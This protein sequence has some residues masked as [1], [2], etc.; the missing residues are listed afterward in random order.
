MESVFPCL[1][2]WLFHYLE[3]TFICYLFLYHLFVREQWLYRYTTVY[4][5]QKVNWPF[6]I[7]SYSCYI[8]FIHK[9]RFKHRYIFIF[10]ALLTPLKKSFQTYRLYF[11][12]VIA[13]FWFPNLIT[14]YIFLIFV[15]KMMKYFYCKLLNSSII[16][17]VYS[18]TLT[19]IMH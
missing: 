10:N 1:P 11:C 19:Y 6:P 18:C 2:F 13:E 14:V 9:N 7:F 15:R 5:G 4:V 12:K 8:S 3:T 16:I 17:Q